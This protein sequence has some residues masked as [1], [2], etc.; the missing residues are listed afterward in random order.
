MRFV[1]F[2]LVLL[3]GIKVWTQDRMYRSIMN[4]ALIAAYRDRAIDMCRR[5]A[6][7]PAEAKLAIIHQKPKARSTS[8]ADGSSLWSASVSAEIVIGNNAVDVAIWDTGNPDW[9]RRFRHPNVVLT[10]AQSASLRCSYD[11]A[12]GIATLSA[13]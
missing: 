8:T 13:L 9:S 12:A 3:A 7:E 2:G 6:R 5:Q 4:D 1:V 11:V 10:S